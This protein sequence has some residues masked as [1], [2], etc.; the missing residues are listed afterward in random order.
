MC[1]FLLRVHDCKGLSL[2]RL[3]TSSE[4]GGHPDFLLGFSALISPTG[5]VF[6]FIYVASQK[7]KQQPKAL[8]H[9]EKWICAPI[10]DQNLPEPCD[11]QS[12]WAIHRAIE[13]LIQLMCK[14]YLQ[15][16]QCN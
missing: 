5:D 7:V 15:S 1:L 6:F 13:Y 3:S 14:V 12:D 9:C 16:E 4:A 11:G 8:G 10:L 2:V